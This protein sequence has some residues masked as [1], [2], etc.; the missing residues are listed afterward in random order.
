[1]STRRAA[2]PLLAA[3]VCCSA[4]S[5][6]EQESAF[7][8]TWTEPI[9]LGPGSD[10]H[11]ELRVAGGGKAA[12]ERTAIAAGLAWLR[13]EQNHGGFWDS[14][15]SHEL[16]VALTSVAAVAMLGDAST[17]RGGAHS[18]PLRKAIAW[19][20]QNQEPGGAFAASTGPHMLATLA[21]TEAYYLSNY[22]LLRKSARKAHWHLESLRA[23]DGGWR[24]RLEDRESDPSLTLWGATLRHYQKHAGIAELEPLSTPTSRW[25]Q[26]PLATRIPTT[27]VLGTAPPQRRLSE[28]AHDQ[29]AA[30]AFTRSWLADTKP[31]DEELASL[32]ERERQ[33]TNDPK[34]KLSIFEWFCSSHALAQAGDAKSLARI[35]S[36]LSAAQVR[37][38]DD[39]G[40][41]QPIGVWGEVGGRVWTTAMAV[42]TLEAPYRYAKIVGR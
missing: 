7:G 11:F 23:P 36:K 9:M 29:R 32:R 2:S 38:G 26:S 19:L 18:E 3:L 5:A 17:M 41:W 6:Q 16:T 21:M 4:T 20:R 24:A 13:R 22:K 10:D 1:M 25:L 42:L 30:N 39:A 28:L 40:S 12:C 31:T 33:W 34:H 8:S 15:G 14:G 35:G 37:D 27:G